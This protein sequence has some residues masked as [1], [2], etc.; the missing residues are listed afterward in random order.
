ML[1]ASLQKVLLR[2]V[3]NTKA[4]WQLNNVWSI[5]AKMWSR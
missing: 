2:M 4:G 1:N 5:P 3:L